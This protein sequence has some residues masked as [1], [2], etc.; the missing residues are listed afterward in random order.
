MADYVDLIGV[1]FEYGGRGDDEYD[2]YG[3]LMELM[4]RDG[5]E[6]PDY[7]SPEDGAKIT[8]IFMGELRL[9]EKCE[10]KEGVAFLFRV[11]GNIHVGY[12]I[13]G[14]KF[15]HTWQHTGGVIVERLSDNGWQNR[16]M[17]IYKYVGE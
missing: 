5:I 7:A 15:V 4:R 10:A 1:P 9:W 13:G 17:G 3:L 8:A 2:C 6:I 11:P 14:D 16:L 12:C